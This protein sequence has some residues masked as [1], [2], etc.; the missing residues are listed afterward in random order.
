M[1]IFR[2][3]LIIGSLV[4]MVGV[5]ETRALAAEPTVATDT[6]VGTAKCKMCHMSQFRQFNAFVTD[7]TQTVPVILKAGVADSKAVGHPEA[8]GTMLYA[9]S[10]LQCETCHG[11][12]SRHFGLGAANRDSEARRS[13]INLPNGNTCRTCHSPHA[14]K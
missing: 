12:G 1:A 2:Y 11:F 3:G 9:K 4:L 14:M 13:T 10:N 6:Y 5:F 7:T 8:S